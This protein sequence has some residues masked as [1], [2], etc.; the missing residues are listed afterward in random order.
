MELNHQH[1][2]ASSPALL[3]A[4]LIVTEAQDQRQKDYREM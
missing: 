1:T 2:G 4:S 3:H